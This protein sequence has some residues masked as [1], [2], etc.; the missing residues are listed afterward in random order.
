MLFVP[1]IIAALLL[2][3]HFLRWGEPGLAL[4][5]LAAPLLLFLRRRWVPAVLTV[6][7][8]AGVGIWV[9][10]GIDIVMSRLALGA[11][12]ARAATI[13]G[14]VALTTALVPL[15]FRARSMRKRYETGSERLWVGAGAFLLTALLLAI[16][17]IKVAVPM[18]LAERFLPGAGWIEVLALSTYAGWIAEKLLEPRHQPLLRRR[19]WLIF[20]ILFFGQLALGLAGLDSLLMTGELHWPIPAVILAGPIY[21]GEGLFMIILLAVTLVLVGPAWCSYLCYFGALDAI[22]A[23]RRNRPEALPRWSTS[24]R[25]ALLA[26]VLGAAFLLGWIGVSPFLAGAS[27]LVFGI[28]GLVVMLVV[29]RRMGT[30]VHC[31]VYCPVGL[32]ADIFGKLSPF[33]LRLGNDCTECRACSKACRY[34]ALPLVQIEKRRPGMTC[35]LCGDCVGACKHGQVEYR[36]FGARGAWVR[37]LFTMIVVALH[38]VFLGVARV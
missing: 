38:A 12:W 30:M 29:T 13:I 22:L 21:R 10:T 6:G 35:T 11:P 31:A 16:V 36:F 25:V 27:A 8:L 3:A 32:V 9:E 15:V 28:G 33:R 19:I 14:I 7:L 24:L 5:C 18:L 4:V 23:E 2:A 34:D 26:V 17:Q 20:T 1:I 37:P